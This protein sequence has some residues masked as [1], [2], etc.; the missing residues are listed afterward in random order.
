MKQLKLAYEIAKSQIGV[1]E[2]DGNEH[3]PQIIEYHI[4]SVLKA[5]TDE[6]PWCSSFVNWCF[7][8]SAILLNPAEALNLLYTNRYSKVEID[9]FMARAYQI[10]QMLG[11][12]VSDIENKTQTGEPVTLGTTSALARSWLTFGVES[13]DLAQGDLVIISRG[14]DGISGHVGFVDHVG[15]TFVDILGGNQADSV[16]VK[17]FSRTKVLGYRKV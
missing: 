5:T 10:A 1:K 16:C 11:Y 6:T 8:M 2:K 9:L 12:P 15:L 7:L 13:K 4:A 14:S 3:N 17:T